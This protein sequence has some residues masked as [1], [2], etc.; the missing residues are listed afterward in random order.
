MYNITIGYLSWKRHDILTQTLQSHKSNGLFD[1]IKPQNRIIFFQELAKKDIDIAYN[2]ECTYLGNSNNIGILDGFI[3]LVEECKTEYFIFSE[4]D[5]YLIENKD[6]TIKILEDCIELLNKDLCDIVKLRHRQN[7]G[8]PLYS[9]PENTDEWL[10][11][12][13]SNFPYK[14]ESLSWVDE[15][16]KVYNNL[17][18]EYICN[19]KWYITTL[20]HQKWSNN[21]FIAKTSYLKNIVLPLIKNINIDIN[22]Y[23][24][25][26][27]I[28]INY[29]NY[30]GK[31]IEF[32]N[33]INLF[34]KTKIGA[35]EGLFTHKDYI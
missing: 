16:N 2:F 17:F 25:L 23:T 15:P 7:P 3:K 18:N 21:I 30:Y 35:G 4:N 32:D 24:G 19:Y 22:K 11:Q 12:D 13:I 29:N 14:L 34:K 33:I 27:D 9:K 20:E 1:L 31:S 28:L 5:W 6:T 8:N 26:E 10:K